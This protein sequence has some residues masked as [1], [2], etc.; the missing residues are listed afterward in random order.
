MDDTLGA[1]RGFYRQ[2]AWEAAFQALSRAAAV[3]PLDASDLEL[4]SASAYLAGHELA[5]VEATER[6]HHRYLEAG[7]LARAVRCSVWL[8]LW[9]LLQGQVGRAS[10]WLARGQ[11]LLE[12]ER[13]PCIEQGYLRLPLAE[14]MLA[15]GE[16]EAAYAC[17]AHAAQL[18]ERFQDADVT[19]CARHLQGRARLE[20]GK[21]EEGLALL[22]EV[23]VAVTAGELSPI[24]TG[25][26]YC[27]VIDACR[28][29]LD[30][31]RAR[32]WNG[33]MEGWCA[34]QPQLVAFTGTCLVHRAEI[35]Q[36]HGAWP[37]A[38]A[39]ART[40][41]ERHRSAALPAPPA[42]LY[43]EGEVH[44]L[45]GE[46]DAAEAAYEAAGR[47]GFEPQPGLALL[48]LAQ[49]RPDAAA[50]AMRRVVG[51]CTESLERARLLPAHVEVL[52]QVGEVAEAERCCLELERLAA[53]VGTD[54]LRAQSAQ[55][56]GAVALAGGDA[57]AAI[58]VLRRALAIWERTQAPY[59]AARAHELAGLACRALGDEDGMR[60][61]LEAAGATYARLGAAPDLA[62]A[63]ALGRAR[64][65]LS[66]HGLTAREM[67]V[68]GLVASGRTNKDIA[69]ALR[70]STKTV[71]R[72]VSNIF[73][74]LDV[75]SRAAATAYAYQHR[76]V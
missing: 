35:M 11:R 33:A 22:D 29:V 3:A 18:G 57:T 16:T 72:H 2:R 19:L 32:E 7:E 30:F 52:L 21:V 59:L 25:L 40:A 42:A 13:R 36:L 9:L 51:A 15:N 45:R 73:L 58:A 8:G 55:A 27:S 14:Q 60:L 38:L 69:H 28:R 76:L 26:L 48:R 54:V 34:A 44:R 23:M 39:A 53:T 63:E 68:L 64:R 41:C 31:G 17:A 71:D 12:R 67:Q 50:A 24:M 56:R 62:R 65:P 66:Q 70:L 74:K 6:A 43:Q 4:L 10:G 5:A 75:G 46:L 47:S 49:G 37:E 1:G 20:Q 61:E